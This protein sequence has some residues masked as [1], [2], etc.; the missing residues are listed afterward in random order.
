MFLAQLQRFLRPA[1]GVV[2]PTLI[3]CA[4]L[5][6][7]GLRARGR[8]PS[9][10]TDGIFVAHGEAYRLKPN[11]S[12]LSTTPSYSCTVNTNALGLRDAAPGPRLLAA[13][14]VAWMGDSATFANGVEYEQSF[15]GLLGDRWRPSGIEVVNLAV[16]GHH[17]QEQEELLR[18]FVRAAPRRPEGVVVVFTPQLMALFEERYHDLVVR[19]GYIFQGRNWLPSYALVTL[20]NT[21]SAYC[22]FRDGLRKL[23]A[24]YLP[25]RGGGAAELLG[26]YARS[27]PAVAPEA[28]R[29][30]EDRI[31]ELDDGIRALGA[32]P[33][34]VYLPT[35]I[36]L[37]AGEILAADPRAGGDF[38]LDHY[39]DALR[40]Q[41]AR[42]GV[43]FVDL[44]PPLRAEYAKGQP[45]WFSQDM[46]YNAATHVVIA[47]ALFE[48]MGRAAW[49]GPRGAA[50]PADEPRR[51][52]AMIPARVAE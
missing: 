39:R 4:V 19:S 47:D 45:L 15:V 24:R 48:L 30:M 2:L 16:G 29:R 18:D 33:V 8:L 41:S 51:A 32:T 49:A 34:H 43:R 9:N 25:A 17:I 31:S 27:F 28:T 35:A 3:V 12:K 13:P 10:V 11:Q 26:M 1:V 23:Q 5:L 20:G 44:T 42:S 21:S 14:Y 52:A 6:E 50:A 46:H 38:A 40:R 22:F 37:R 36:D 7:V